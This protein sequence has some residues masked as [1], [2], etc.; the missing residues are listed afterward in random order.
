MLIIAGK[1]YVAPDHRDEYVAVHED[2]IRRARAYP[3]SLD[4][5][6]TADQIE[7]GRVI[8]PGEGHKHFLRTVA[9]DGDRIEHDTMG[10]RSRHP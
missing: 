7:P 2:L 1:L 10:G 5:A 3:G 8:S 4:L 6:I 9:A